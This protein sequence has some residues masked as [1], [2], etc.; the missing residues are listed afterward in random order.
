MRHLLL[1]TIGFF[2]LQ[3]SFATAQGDA[4]A[5]KAFGLSLVQ[6]LY[7]NQCSYVFDHLDKSVTSMQ[8]GQRI[9]IEENMRPVFCED[10]PIRKDISNSYTHYTEQYR[11]QIYDHKAFKKQFP[12]WA[13][14][15][16][17]K[18]GDYFFDGAHPKA[19]GHT[20]LFTAESQI[21]YILRY[22]EGDWI[23]IGI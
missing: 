8:G 22:T 15:I 16:T 18:A 6:S 12:A 10:L 3:A 4:E 20:R 23:I 17:L 7:D 2:L 11:P 14:H 21:R 1:L 13:N 9:A 5:A 19:A